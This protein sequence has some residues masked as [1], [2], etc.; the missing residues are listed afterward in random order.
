[1]LHFS[2]SNQKLSTE[3]IR[4]ALIVLLHHN[5]VSVYVP[6]PDD[7]D[8]DDINV[9]VSQSSADIEYKLNVD[10]VIA[11][12]RFPHLITC[13]MKN[14]GPVEACIMQELAQGGRLS[15][16]QILDKMDIN[17]SNGKLDPCVSLDDVRTAFEGLIQKRYVVPAPTVDVLLSRM[18][19][20]A[21]SSS[22]AIEANGGA[23]R[24]RK[25]VDAKSLLT[26][27]STG[28][29]GSK[30]SS[31]AAS[32]PLSH[33]SSLLPLELRL[34]Q[35]R[36]APSTTAGTVGVDEDRVGGGVGG[37][38]SSDTIAGNDNSRRGGRGGGRGQA[39]RRGRG[40]G[41]T[42]APSSSA[43]A[44]TSTVAAVV[45][46]ADREPVGNGGT[47]MRRGEGGALV[48]EQWNIPN[49]TYACAVTAYMYGH[50]YNHAVV[51]INM[52]LCHL[53][54]VLLPMLLLPGSSRGCVVDLQL[55]PTR[56]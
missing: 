34:M 44:A 52:L 19:A 29:D 16:G 11:R 1:M 48:S 54:D 10:G 26:E 55:G 3:Y 21:I 38:S 40:R 15:V 12:L 49:Y 23:A 39:G 46:M 4:D 14:F 42:S 43:V 17:I 56:A 5:C 35:Q 53:H 33:S 18:R 32:A 8:G 41:R 2:R 25:R 20:N 50:N 31:G 47:A 27:S 45:D 13:A 28:A 9:L 30:A 36:G 24:K 37:G 51:I 7:F 22:A 6:T